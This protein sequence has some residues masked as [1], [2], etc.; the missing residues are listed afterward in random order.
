MNKLLTFIALMLFSVLSFAQPINNDC[1]GIIDLGE[2]PICPSPAIYTNLDATESNIG[3]DNFPNCFNGAPT[4]DVWF[5]FTASAGIEDYV[6]TVTGTPDGMGSDPILMPQVALYRGDICA[7]DELVILDCADAIAGESE[8]SMLVNGLTAGVTYYLRIN[9]WT[10]STPNW[11]SFSLC[12][13]E[14]VQTVYTIDEGSAS[15]CS[16]ELY[17]SGGAN[18]DYGSN[19]N[20]IFTICPDDPHACINFSLHNYNVENGDDVINFYDGD[21]VLAPLI[22]EIDGGGNGQNHGGVC[23]NV[24]ASSGCLTVQFSS[25]GFL[26]FEGFYGSWECTTENCPDPSPID[27]SPNST[28]AEIEAALQNPLMDISVVNIICPDNAYG[29]FV[30]TDETGLGMNDGLLITTGRA[31][32]VSN[33]ATILASTDHNATGDPDLNYLQT[34]YGNG[35]GFINDACSVELDVTPKSGNIGFDYVFGS[36]EYKQN[37]SQ[38]SNDLMAIMISGP[39]ISGEPGLNNQEH[40]TFLPG[41]ALIQIQTVNPGTRWEYFRN[42]EENESLVYNG[43]TSDFLG[44]RKYMVAQK[45]VSPCQTYRVKMAIGDTDPNDDSGLFVRPTTEGVP[46]VSLN[47][48]TGIDYL[49]EGCTDIENLIDISLPNPISTTLVFQVQIGGTATKNIDYQA[50]IPPQIIIQPGETGIQIPITVIDDNIAEGTETIELTLITNFGCGDVVFSQTTIEIEDELTVNIAPS[51]DTVFV[52]DGIFTADLAATGAATYEWTPNGVFDD[53]TAANPTATVANDQTVTVTGSLG[54]CSA[55]DEVFLQIV[56]PQVNIDQASTEICEGESFQITSTNNVGDEGLSW[57]PAFGLDDPNSTDPL[58]SPNFTTTY[59]LTVETATGGCTATDEVTVTVEPFDFPEITVTDTLICQNSSVLLAEPVFNSSTVFEWSPGDGLNSTTIPN[60]TATPDV[61]TTYTLTA[62]SINGICT[63]QATVHI[64]VFPADVAI[65]N[66]DTIEICLGDTIALNSITST[67]GLGLIWTPADSLSSTTDETVLANPIYSTWYYAT[68]E[69]GDCIVSDSV[70]IQ[71]DSLPDLAI[72]AIPDKESYCEGEVVSLASQGYAV[73]KYPEIEHIWIP[74]PGA[75]SEDTLLNLV[76]NATETAI[77]TRYSMN[78]A[79]SDTAQIEIIVVP[80]AVITI[81]PD[82]PIVCP[83]ETIQLVASS[84]DITDFEWSPSNGLSCDDCPNPVVN[85]PGSITYQVSGEFM[86]CPAT[87]QVT[88]TEEQGPN[89]DLTSTKKVCEGETVLLNSVVDPDATYIWTLADG[90]VFSN[91]PMPMVT[92]TEPTE[93]FLSVTKGDC[94][95]T[96]TSITI[97]PISEVDLNLSISDVGP[98]CAGE[99]VSLSAQIDSPNGTY[100]WTHD[101]T[102]SGPNITEIPEVGITNY[103]LLFTSAESDESDLV[104]FTKEATISVEV[105]A[106][107]ILDSLVANPECVFEGEELSLEAITSPSVLN[108]P[109][110]TWQLTNGTPQG[111][112]FENV[113]M[114]TA[115]TLE[116]QDS[117]QATY[118][119]IIVD[120][121]GCRAD[122]EV[123]V[124]I[125]NSFIEIPNAFTPDGDEMNDRFNLLRSDNVEVLDFKVW[126]RW[127]QLVYENDSNDFGWDGTKDGNPAAVDVY[128]YSIK[129]RFGEI[130]ETLTGELTLLR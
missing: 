63:E 59:T 111:E 68:L 67:S 32:D 88:V 107:F 128:V 71:V 39:G 24:S 121:A 35:F 53:P 105:A 74:A 90:T 102:L 51:L 122:A 4:R 99:E 40:L 89:F 72:S 78:N 73:S 106:P 57:E 114:V 70:F 80:T 17:D 46:V 69:V 41:N 118:Q 10:L 127:G 119:V 22:G 5:Q 129:Y 86:G 101:A 48:L 26:N 49:V 37:V 112:T 50:S 120:E 85:P 55:T 64:D 117:A 15:V 116:N 115:A 125:K 54:T 1:A 13:E 94:P 47:Y 20:F 126:N 104:C 19:E 109:V 23:Y 38:F 108:N 76:I 60:A 34:T 2:A 87:A 52:C 92:V 56:S 103:T 7:F 29:T 93:Y 113:I 33:P 30:A 84:P 83:A 12:V 6:I 42:N 97:N 44:E 16:G 62:T 100:A 28:A 82:N 61:S 66:P 43:L 58:A 8:V 45:S 81:T 98:I 11:G 123:D 65:S 21:N 77:Y 3:N 9:D 96:E 25:D 18:G 95:P 31:T 75:I 130:E 14:F 124:T 36:D 27:I 110:Y 79:C 91:D